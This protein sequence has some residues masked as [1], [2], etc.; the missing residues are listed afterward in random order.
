MSPP[1]Q[2]MQHS[3]PPSIWSFFTQSTRFCSESVTSLPVFRAAAP[4]M[5]TTVE[6]VQHEPQEPWFLMSATTPSVRQSTAVGA[7]LSETSCVAPACDGFGRLWSF[8]YDANSSAVQSAN[9][10]SRP[11]AKPSAL[12]SCSRTIFAFWAKTVSRWAHSSTVSYVFSNL[13][14][15]VMKASWTASTSVSPAARQGCVRTQ[16]SAVDTEQ[17]AGDGFQMP[18][19][20][21]PSMCCCCAETPGR[22]ARARASFMV[23]V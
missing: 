17:Q 3:S 15:K 8:W 13:V 2:P 22:S 5:D 7:A 14:M 6:N 18:W 19:P 10:L 11:R 12:A 20:S 16:S 21:A 23:L 1:E 9:W 4:S